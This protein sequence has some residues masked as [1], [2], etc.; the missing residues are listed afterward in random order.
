MID[1]PPC[2]DAALRERLKSP[3]A[4]YATAETTWPTEPESWTVA[5]SS[6]TTVHLTAW[7]GDVPLLPD[8]VV[9]SGIAH[10]LGIVAR[11][12]ARTPHAR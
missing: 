11:T 1:L 10:D 12:P 8:G 5:S 9:S 3:P 4:Y 2:D 7:T 6:G